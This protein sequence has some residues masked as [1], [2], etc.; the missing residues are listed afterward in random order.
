MKFVSHAASIHVSLA[1]K[2]FQ[3]SMMNARHAKKKRRPVVLQ[4]FHRFHGKRRII[5]P[6]KT[7]GKTVDS[8]NDGTLSVIA[9]KSH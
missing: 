2:Y 1:K 6:T 8:I 9:S 3:A 7:H 5:W 4:A